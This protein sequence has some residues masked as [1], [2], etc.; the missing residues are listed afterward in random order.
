VLGNDALDAFRNPFP[1]SAIAQ[2]QSF[3]IDLTQ[4][5]RNIRQ[6]PDERLD[7]L[8]RVRRLARTLLEMRSEAR[9]V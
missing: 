2:A 8:E 9:H 6:N 3:G 1:G 5:A 4:L 7:R